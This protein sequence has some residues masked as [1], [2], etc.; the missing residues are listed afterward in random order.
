MKSIYLP[1]AIQ[2][3]IPN[4]IRILAPKKPKQLALP[5]EFEKELQFGPDDY[6]RSGS[7]KGI[8]FFFS[9]YT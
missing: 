7:I 4:R 6:L 9:N 1:V 2:T 3:S 8:L 5:Q